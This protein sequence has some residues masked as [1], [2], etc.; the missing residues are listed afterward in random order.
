MPRPHGPTGHR[1]SRQHDPPVPDTDLP[2]AAN[3][4]FLSN[5]ML[6]TGSTDIVKAR[7]EL[8]PQAAADDLFHDLGGAAEDRL[9]AAEPPELI[10]V[11]ESI[12]VVLTPV[13]A[14]L[15]LVSASRG[16]RAV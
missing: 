1:R 2:Q 13:K 7:S 16:V 5:I 6:E 15:P 11:P 4:N 14:G 8:Q 3:S 12:G 9:H 10:T